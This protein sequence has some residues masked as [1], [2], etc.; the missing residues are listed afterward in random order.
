MLTLTNCGSSKQA[1]VP[2]DDY[3]RHWEHPTGAER[4]LCANDRKVLSGFVL[5]PGIF[6][7]HILKLTRFEYVAALHAFDEFG[8]FLTG[9]NSHTRV[10]TLVRVAARIGGWRRRD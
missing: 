8:V 9:D 5:Q 6:D 2:A 10:L 1:Q 7:H 4:D 3:L